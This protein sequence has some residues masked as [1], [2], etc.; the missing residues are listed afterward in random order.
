MRTNFSLAQLADPDL[1][2][3]E[4]AL[5]ACVHCGI[6]TA[7]CPTYVLLGDER[8]G[9]RGR[10]VMMQEM[11]EADAVPSAETVHHIDR[12]LSCLNCRTACPSGVDYAKLIDTARA[13]IET[14]YRR[15]P[16]ERLLRGFVANMSVRPS[17]MRF[18]MMLARLFAPI[19]RRL[20]GSLGAMADV[21]WKAQTDEPDTFTLETSSDAMRVAA[22]PGCVQRVLAPSID[23]AIARVLARR[24]ITAVALE[25]AGCCGAVAHH[26]GREDEARDFAKRAIEAFE[27][28]GA[29]H[30]S[31]GATGCAAHMKSYADLFRADAHWHARATAFAA[32]VRDF[33]ELAEPKSAR[34]PSELRVAYHAAC[35]LQHGMRLAGQGE[36]LAATAGHE[37]LSVPEGHLCC[38]SAGSYSLL[39]P[40][41][42]GALRARKLGNIRTLQPDVIVSGNIGCLHHLSGADAPPVLH[43]AELLDWSEGGPVPPA[44]AHLKAVD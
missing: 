11:L 26:L 37:V 41:L 32:K 12:C 19:S 40:E 31:I 20:P 35:S 23:P 4:R 13:H 16:S 24:N 5:R 29:A 14:H 25:G 22:M 28:N 42:S 6:C 34:P 8:D 38:G 18:G 27:R 21:A 15:P 39:Q 3:A 17:L 1:A 43:L 33:T 7:T 10:I 36:A 30:V 2:A 9:P 44:L